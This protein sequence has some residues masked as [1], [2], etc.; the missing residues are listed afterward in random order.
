MSTVALFEGLWRPL[1]FAHRGASRH[2]P[3]NTWEAFELGIS[4]GADV[5]ELDIHLTRD[6]DVVVI[7]DATLER[8]TNGRG[9]VCEHTYAELAS[10]DAG[11]HF[12]IRP[13]EHPFR[14]RGVII[15]RLGEVLAQFS[16][17]AFNIELKQR[18]PSM[19][20]PVLD[21]LERTGASRVV[22]AAEDG[23]IMGELEAARSGVPLGLSRQ[24]VLAVLRAAYL[25]R[26]PRGLEGRALQIPPFYRGLPV[27]TGPV[28]RA[29]R[30]AGLEV[31][32]WTL[33]DPRAAAKWLERGVDGVMSNDPSAL[34]AMV[35]AA[36]ERLAGR[37]LGREL[38]LARRGR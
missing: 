15:P 27:A 12:G 3:E 23:A 5:L 30:A 4:V 29:A 11:Y 22:L 13:G 2:A 16:R 36:K 31:H 24:Q 7:H 38:A 9:R 18:K 26:V 32:L 6:G 17:A 25:G 34:A 28:L 21:I 8:T 19:V 20:R 1:L 33:D 14:D 35:I 37:P 10:L